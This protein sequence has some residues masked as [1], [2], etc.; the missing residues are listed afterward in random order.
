MAVAELQRKAETYFNSAT[1]TYTHTYNV[2]YYGA[3]VPGGLDFSDVSI[4][5]NNSTTL[6][7]IPGLIAVAIRADATNRGYTVAAGKVLLPTYQVA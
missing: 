1:S 6:A 2:A 3:D 7:S 4:N 5:T